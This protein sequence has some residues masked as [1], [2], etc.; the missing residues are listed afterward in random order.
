MLLLA[1]ADRHDV[2]ARRGEANPSC[3]HLGRG[4][5]FVKW[6]A[7]KAKREAASYDW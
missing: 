6:K 7:E 5:E 4:A 3:T 1:T 2:A